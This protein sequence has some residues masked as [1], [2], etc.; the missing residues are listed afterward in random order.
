MH[1]FAHS[2]SNGALNGAPNGAGLLPAGFGEVPKEVEAIRDGGGEPTGLGREPGEVTGF[3]R[4]QLLTARPRGACRHW[5][6]AYVEGGRPIVSLAGSGFSYQK[7]LAQIGS[8]KMFVFTGSG[9]SF[10]FATD[11]SNG[12]RCLKVC[13]DNVHVL[14]TPGAA[15]K[16]T[17]SNGR[18]GVGEAPTGVGAGPTGVGE[19]AGTGL[20]FP[21][22][23]YSPFYLRPV[24]TDPTKSPTNAYIQVYP[25]D[26][27]GVVAG[28]NLG[29]P[30]GGYLH[31]LV[32][33]VAGTWPKPSSGPLTK[34]GDHLFF[35][36]HD[37]KQGAPQTQGL[38]AGMALYRFRYDASGNPVLAIL[39]P[40]GFSLPGTAPSGA[41]T[42]TT[43]STG[44]TGIVWNQYAWMVQNSGSNTPPG[45]L[46][47]GVTTSGSWVWDPSDNGRWVWY[48]QDGTFAQINGYWVYGDSRAFQAPGNEWAVIPMP[49]T[50]PDGTAGTWTQAHRGYWVWTP[51]AAVADYSWVWWL[52]GFV[53]VGGVVYELVD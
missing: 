29:N 9:G 25:S 43:T 33:Q 47:P 16:W 42:A 51:G 32:S 41:I 19:A 11:V 10:L 18:T 15:T 26:P 23:D 45:G 6:L 24:G 52:L 5:L 35:T 37:S 49:T 8:G 22:S 7:A 30:A 53:V 14:Q 2:L 17:V 27:A 38:P 21:T 20:I 44:P 48:P 39:S 50:S 40:Q 28:T 3:G 4:I 34:S 31:S 1:A 12:R 46:P 13:V 36:F